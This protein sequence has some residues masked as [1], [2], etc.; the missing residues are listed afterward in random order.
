M[1]K[2]L[3][4]YNFSPLLYHQI[5]SLLET[6]PIIPTSTLMQYGVMF[7]YALTGEQ[8]TT[9]QIES[10]SENMAHDDQEISLISGEHRGVYLAEQQLLQAFR[11][12]NPEYLKALEKSVS[13]SSGVKASVGD[14]LRENK[15]NLL[16][17]LTLC[18]RASIEGGLSPSIAYSLHDYYADR[19]ERCTNLAETSRLSGELMEDFIGRVHKVRTADGLSRPIKDACDYISF[20]LKENPGLKELAARAGYAEYYF[21]K[22]FKKETGQTVN[23]YI[24]HKKVEKACS[25]L[26]NTLYKTEDIMEETGFI[27]K[28]HFYAAFSRIMGMSPL[29]YR[30]HGEISDRTT[31]V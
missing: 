7:H 3:D 8:I 26:K 28:S 15:N 19:I 13:L 21:S 11:E 9:S 6:V 16:V 30:E 1:R 20:H 18:S 10:L 22:K 29:E 24:S 14:S 25:L 5:L 2:K 17:L 27:S 12:G 4:S 31:D 23:D